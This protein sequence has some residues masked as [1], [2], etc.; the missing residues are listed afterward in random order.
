MAI[1]PHA[2]DHEVDAGH[3]AVRGGQDFTEFALRLGGGCGRGKFAPDAVDPSGRDPERLEEVLVCEGKVA[4]RVRWG[5]AALIP[6]EKVDGAEAGG[7]RG[8][9]VGEGRAK[10]PGDPPSAEGDG[11]RAG[12]GAGRCCKPDELP[13]RGRG[14]LGVG[15]KLQ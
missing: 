10:P 15:G 6:P 1:L 4:L 7:L 14:E 11:S 9:E 3:G 5:N 12:G 8:G 13:G 2:E